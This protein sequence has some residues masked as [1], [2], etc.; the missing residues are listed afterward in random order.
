MG[1]KFLCVIATFDEDTSKQMKEIEFAIKELGIS[2]KQTQDVPHHITLEYFDTSQEEVIKQLLNEVASN[3]KAFYLNF[4]HIGLFGLNV[5]F[6]AP[7]VN[8]EL[9]ELYC[10]FKRESS[11]TNHNWTAH[12]TLLIDEEE[13]IQ[14]ALEIVAKKFKHL[15]SK[16]EKLSLYEFFPTKFIA[17]YK[18]QD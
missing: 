8:Y 14:K 13:N 16:V 7:D 12:A 5:L 10:R 11:D 15:G 2:G 1:D 18:L 9:L 3:T 6:L 17:E 4:N